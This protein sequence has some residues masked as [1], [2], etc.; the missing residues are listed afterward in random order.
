MNFSSCCTEPSISKMPSNINCL[1][2][3]PKRKC[4]I[5]MKIKIEIEV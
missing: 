1:R 2:N 5:I 3:L 4:M